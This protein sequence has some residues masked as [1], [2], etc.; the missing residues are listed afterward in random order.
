MSPEHGEMEDQMRPMMQAAVVA[1]VILLNV[2]CGDSEY[3]N[4]L[5]EYKIGSGTLNCDAAGIDSISVRLENSEREEPIEQEVACDDSGQLLIQEIPSD[6]YNMS[7]EGHDQEGFTNFLGDLENFTVAPDETN[8][9]PTI[10]ISEIRSAEI[11]LMWE[12]ERGMCT[13]NHV[14]MIHIQLWE[15]SVVNVYDEKVD[16]ILEEVKIMNLGKRKYDLQVR[17]L[18]MDSTNS[19][20]PEYNYYFNK[21]EIDLLDDPRQ[22]ISLTFLP[23]QGTND[24]ECVQL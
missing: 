5:V 9:T 16:C 6:V 12:F 23:C 10:T 11:Y 8:V 15:D 3:G 2:G 4:V 13:S 22:K 20:R 7:L 18:D 21:N 17:A 24:P 14:G 1:T 19:S